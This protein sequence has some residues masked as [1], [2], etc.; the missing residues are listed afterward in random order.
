MIRLYRPRVTD[1]FVIRACCCFQSQALPRSPSRPPKPVRQDVIGNILPRQTLTTSRA[2]SESS[3][4]YKSSGG[5]LFEQD[6]DVEA[7]ASSSKA[8]MPIF[9]IVLFE[10]KP[11]ITH[12]QVEDV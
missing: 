5:W 8:K 6:E 11:T 9:H 10:F 2:Y 1:P 4:D 12:A 3:L 7:T